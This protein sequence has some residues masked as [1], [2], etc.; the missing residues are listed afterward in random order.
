MEVGVFLLSHSLPTSESPNLSICLPGWLTGW[1]DRFSRGGNHHYK[2]RDNPRLWSHHYAKPWS[3]G[4]CCSNPPS[5]TFE[6][7]FNEPAKA[8]CCRPAGCCRCRCCKQRPTQKCFHVVEN[9]H[10]NMELVV[11]SPANNHYGCAGVES[12][13]LLA[14]AI[15]CHLCAQSSRKVLLIKPES[16]MASQPTT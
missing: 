14:D 11:E 3:V 8:T 4:C 10:T 5:G 6:P 15:R 12:S 9:L 13:Q 2:I 1:L 16:S 7:Q